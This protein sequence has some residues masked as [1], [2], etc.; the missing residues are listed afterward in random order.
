MAQAALS[1]AVRHDQL[2]PQSPGGNG[3]GVVLALLVHAMLLL[4]LTTAVNWR[5]QTP[6]VVSAELWASVPQIAAPAP[7]PQQPAPTP[8]PTPV[9]P[10]QPAPPPRVDPVMPEVDIAVERA[11]QKKAEADRKRA[12]EAA[13][14]EKK[15][16]AAAADKKR[17]EDDKRKLEADRKKR[18]QEAREAK[19]E[20]EKLAQQREANLRRMMGQAGAVTSGSNATSGTGT[21]AQNAAP[22]AAYTGRLIARIRPNIVYTGDAP[23]S[24][25]AEVEVTAAP[26]GTIISR[27]LS[28]SSGHPEWDEAVL[29]A[30]DRTPSLPRDTDGRVPDRLTIA[31]KRD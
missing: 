22:S 15:R 10:P 21:A 31:F 7:P 3:P 20:E 2:L 17:A 13:E 6:E 9:S 14:A 18:E 19:A 23:P 27:R 8:A 25:T 28:K 4:A 29:R 26:A 11:R 1:M 12:E 5:T 24:A 16:V 30:I